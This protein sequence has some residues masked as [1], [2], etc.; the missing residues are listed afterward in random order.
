MTTLI[1]PA[2]RKVLAVPSQVRAACGHTMHVRIIGGKRHVTL[3][4][5]CEAEAEKA[6]RDELATK[7]VH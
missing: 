2:P 3:L 1:P 7:G 5:D 4:C 6:R